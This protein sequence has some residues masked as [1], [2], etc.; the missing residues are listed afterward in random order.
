M[1]AQG[2]IVY[3]NSANLSVDYFAKLGDRFV[4]PDYENPA[5]FFMDFLSQE[6]I[7][8]ANPSDVSKKY[9]DTIE[10]LHT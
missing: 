10:Y 8:G 4:C 9:C 2:K 6:S 3:F 5:D 7:E 1:L